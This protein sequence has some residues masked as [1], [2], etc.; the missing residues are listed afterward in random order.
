MDANDLILGK[1]ENLPVDDALEE[2]IKLCL[3][4]KELLSVM[5]EMLE[6]F[7]ENPPLRKRLHIVVQG[8]PLGELSILPL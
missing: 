6:V 8:P 4:K 1:V 2:N 5:D 3:E 7:K